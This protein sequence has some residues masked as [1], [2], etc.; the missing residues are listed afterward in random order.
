[1]SGDEILNEYFDTIG[2]R[3]KIFEESDRAIKTKRRIPT[4]NGG[5]GTRPKRLRRN[6][7]QVTDE[8]LLGTA[9][10]WSPPSGSWED[11]IEMI[12]AGEEDNDGHLI[13]FLTWKNGQKTKHGTDV[14]YKKCPQKVVHPLVTPLA[15]QFSC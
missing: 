6:E 13:V 10:K 7:A 3:H 14:I 4:T 15:C 2:G 8:T 1:M 12:D 11:E 9:K 5:F